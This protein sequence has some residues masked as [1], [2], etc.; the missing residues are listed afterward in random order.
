MKTP[1]QRIAGS[2]AF[3]VLSPGEVREKLDYSLDKNRHL[4]NYQALT[5][6]DQLLNEKS[7]SSPSTPFIDYRLC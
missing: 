7:T 6:L 5:N 2:K 1:S 4:L 3:S